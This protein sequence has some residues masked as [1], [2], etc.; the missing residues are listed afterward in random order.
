M[1]ALDI[2]FEDIATSF[3]LLKLVQDDFLDACVREFVV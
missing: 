1:I 3:G 2:A